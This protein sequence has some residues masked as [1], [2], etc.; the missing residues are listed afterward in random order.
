MPVPGS[1]SAGLS[2]A[3]SR[4]PRWL[5][6]H[7]WQ[8]EKEEGEG[9]REE[10]W[11][12]GVGGGGG[13]GG[14]DIPQELEWQAGCSQVEIGVAPLKCLDKVQSATSPKTQD[15]QFP[16]LILAVFSYDPGHPGP[17]PLSHSSSPLPLHSRS[18][19]NNPTEY[20]A[21]QQIPIAKQRNS[22]FPRFFFF[23]LSGQSHPHARIWG[24][25]ARIIH[26]PA[27]SC[28]L[29]KLGSCWGSLF[30]QAGLINEECDGQRGLLCLARAFC[31]TGAGQPGLFSDHLVSGSSTD[32]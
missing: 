15:Q 11:G 17:P 26:Q 31:W 30:L 19:R 24:N 5:A 18:L 8:G 13:G 29:C 16:K 1:L 25:K 7:P 28:C 23:T 20:P 12:E 14:G 27:G 2:V 22:R 6:L 3:L 21:I 4:A 32:R 9:R 10:E